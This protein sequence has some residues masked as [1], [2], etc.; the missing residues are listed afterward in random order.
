MDLRHLRRLA[1]LIG[2]GALAA[3]GAAVAAGGP[4]P[5]PPD[6]ATAGRSAVDEPQDA[7]GEHGAAPDGASRGSAAA[8]GGDDVVDVTADPAANHHGRTV[9]GFATGTDLEGRE[10]G[11]AI[12]DL[13]SSNR[14]DSGNAS[15]EEQGTSTQATAAHDQAA[16]D[17][18][19]V[20][21]DSDGP[22]GSRETGEEAS[23]DGRANAGD[24]DDS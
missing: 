24:R 7:E 11:E 4:Q 6:E 18:R 19:D 10:K 12:A 8:G 2:A 15:T 5:E 9:S 17:L 16:E 23:A 14:Q 21:D 22:E 13:A 3:G 1:A 20:P